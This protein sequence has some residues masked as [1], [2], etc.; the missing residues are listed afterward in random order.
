MTYPPVISP[1]QADWWSM[2]QKCFRLKKAFKQK[3]SRV[4]DNNTK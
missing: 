4:N 2:E 3:Q 1:T